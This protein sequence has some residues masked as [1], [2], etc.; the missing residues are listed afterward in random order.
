MPRPRCKLN[1]AIGETCR[2]QRTNKSPYCSTKCKDRFNYLK[3]QNKKEV[4]ET[5]QG[6]TARGP[7]YEEFCRDYASKLESKKNTQQQIA[8]LM[9][10]NRTTVTK[11][12]KAFLEDKANVEAQKN[13]KMSEAAKQSLIDFKD[14]RDRYFKTETGDLYETADFH[15][16]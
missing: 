1:D 11:M 15:E 13:W 12:Y 14:F 16:N 7:R 8:D 5:K 10:L 4:P 9:G 6:T 3:K 2:K